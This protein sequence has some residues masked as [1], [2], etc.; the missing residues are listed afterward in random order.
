MAKSFVVS[1]ERAAGETTVG[2][3]K[4]IRFSLSV[5]IRTMKKALTFGAASEII[6]M[7]VALRDAVKAG[8]SIQMANE[9]GE[10]ETVKVTPT[11]RKKLVKDIAE[12]LNKA[13]AEDKREAPKA[14]KEAPTQAL[15]FGRP[16]L[17]KAMNKK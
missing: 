9:A 7:T 5:D 14:K 13:G 6:S 2:Q 4:A 1:A 16:D 10:I 8:G 3:G 12:Q 15:V 11:L 17:V